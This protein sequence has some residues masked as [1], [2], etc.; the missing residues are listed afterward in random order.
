LPF[1]TKGT[2]IRI[3]GR[4]EETRGEIIMEGEEINKSSENVRY[5]I[6]IL[7]FIQNL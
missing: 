2:Y 7:Y 6:L 5:D 3:L 4:T 1:T